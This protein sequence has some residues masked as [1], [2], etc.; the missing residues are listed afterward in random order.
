MKIEKIFPYFL[1]YI[2]YFS[3][4]VLTS[5]TR[6]SYINLLSEAPAL[7]VD[8]KGST[9]SLIESNTIEWSYQNIDSNKIL[10]FEISL[11]TSPGAVDAV[12]WIDVGNVNSYK[13]QKALDPLTVYYVN[14]RYIDKDT[15]VKSAVFTS[16]GFTTP[17]NQIQQIGV[18]EEYTCALNKKGKMKCW[19]D[20]NQGQLGSGNYV[21]IGKNTGSIT[22]LAPINFGVDLFAKKITV[23]VRHACALLNNNQVKCWGANG[24]GQLGYEDDSDRIQPSAL[25]FVDIGAGRSA[26]EILSGHSHTCVVLDNDKLKCWGANWAGQLGYD[27]T[28]N[29]G[30]LSGS[31]A[32]L[33]EVDLGLNRTV[34]QATLGESHTCAILDNDDL[35][36]WGDNSYGQLGYDNTTNQGDTPGSMAGLSA[37]NLGSGRTAKYVSAKGT[38]TCAILDNDDLKCWGRNT[39]GQLGY[40]D[41]TNRGGTPGS[42]SNLVAIDLGVGRT[43]K[44]VTQNSANTCVIL[45]TDELKCWGNNNFGMLGYN[46]LDQTRGSV[47]GSMSVLS[48]VNVGLNKNVVE[49][50][51]SENHMC[52]VLDNSELKCW[53]QNEKGQLGYEDISPRGGLSNSVATLPTINFGVGYFVSQIAASGES[54][55]CAILG[56]GEVKCWG[57]NGYLGYDDLLSHGHE[58]GSMMSL[59]NVNLGVGR[60]AKQIAKSN[61]H[62]CVILDND[63]VKCWGSGSAM[64]YESNVAIGGSPGDMAALGYVNLGLGRTAKKIAAGAYFTCVIL[65]NDQVKCWGMNYLGN[66]GY[67]DTNPRGTQS[68]DMAA[69]GYVNLGMGRT[70]KDIVLGWG[71]ACAILDNDQ[72][73]CWGW[74]SRG[75]LGYG[76]TTTRGDVPGSMA[77]LGYVNLGVG[78]TVKEVSIGEE[79][80]CAILDNDQLKCWGGNVYGELGYEN[81]IQRTD[82]SALSYVN[83][84]SGRT[85]KHISSG[86]YFTCAILD[87]DQMKCWGN[88]GFGGLGY[89]NYQTYGAFPDSMVNLPFVDLGVGRTVK[90]VNLGWAYACVIL[91]NDQAKCWGNANFSGALGQDDILARGWGLP[92]EDST[93]QKYEP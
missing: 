43:A 26:K 4:I 72:L 49:V 10:S 30:D 60:T 75:Q 29:I 55:T 23:S 18:G 59:P 85:A 33:Q 36:C 62:V 89:N 93:T 20:N 12:S 71:H 50:S 37:V 46:D 70:A 53:G 56:N 5:C 58:P 40:D 1:A 86:R 27:S 8:D 34:K 44:K 91:D 61:S 25:P 77:A 41:T 11:G 81:T 65:D 38:S 13:F 69:L 15:N 47:A 19:G 64:P 17:A 54:N 7:T 73:K 22:N 67:D 3:F 39:N 57:G 42:M 35:K 90:S 24:S 48:T 14:I 21:G 32:G 51:M 52:V 28:S 78:R 87:N 80:T 88:G 76:D 92:I 6:A 16:S 79:F 63:Q 9:Q 66:L 83:L 84:G 82:P 2:F 74:N 45:D 68:G 31:M